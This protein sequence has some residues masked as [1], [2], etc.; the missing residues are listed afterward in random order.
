MTIST[1]TDG[2]I[3]WIINLEFINRYAI[4]LSVTFSW[5]NI[6]IS[7]S[8][9]SDTVPTL[10]TLWK[11]SFEHVWVCQ[12]PT[13]HEST[14]STS[15]W[16][17]PTDKQNPGHHVFNL[18][19]P[20]V[21]GTYIFPVTTPYTPYSHPLHLLYH[22]LSADNF[23]NWSMNLIF[24]PNKLNLNFSCFELQKTNIHLLH[25]NYYSEFWTRRQLLLYHHP[26]TDRLSNHTSGWH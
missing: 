5:Q 6:L 10:S 26:V 16:Y 15:S 7:L 22:I 12:C 19:Y 1:E 21:P 2:N 24:N 14:A 17:D 25:N 3:S 18:F 8:I 4:L 23:L 13:S 11:R 9:P 20:T